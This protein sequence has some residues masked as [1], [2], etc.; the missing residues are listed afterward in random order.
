MTVRP[1][2]AAHGSLHGR[3]HISGCS[4]NTRSRCLKIIDNYRT[5][6]SLSKSW[7]WKTAD[8]RHDAPT[9]KSGVQVE[10][11]VHADSCSIYV[12][13]IDGS[14]RLWTHVRN[15][16]LLYAHVMAGR[17]PFVLNRSG[18]LTTTGRAPVHLPI[19]L[20]HLC[21]VLGE[22]LPGPILDSRTRH[23]EGYCYPFGRRLTDLIAKV[24]PVTWLKN[25][26]T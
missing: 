1:P 23:V 11:R 20:G 7:D 21:T 26:V 3:Q 8:F 4:L 16:A 10:Q 6:F 15:W 17:P 24:I 9:S 12:I 22:G 25:E 13:V 14:P 18:W 19:P 2:S 5:G